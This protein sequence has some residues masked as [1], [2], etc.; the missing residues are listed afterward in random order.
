MLYFLS[1]YFWHWPR[2]YLRSPYVPAAITY[3][4]WKIVFRVKFYFRFLL[5]MDLALTTLYFRTAFKRAF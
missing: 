5:R 1:Y 3:R 4:F 2:A